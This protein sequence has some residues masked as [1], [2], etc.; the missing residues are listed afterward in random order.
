M[1]ERTGDVRRVRSAQC[2]LPCVL[3]TA[4]AALKKESALPIDR[5]LVAS[6]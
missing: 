6:V 1:A 4:S 2:V 5:A 3:W